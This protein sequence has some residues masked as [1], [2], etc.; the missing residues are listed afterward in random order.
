MD[1][2]EPIMEVK[3]DFMVSPAGDSDPSLR[4]A[5]FLKPIANGNGTVSESE[6]PFFSGHPIFEQWPLKVHFNGWRNLHPRW[7][8]WV[9]ALRLRYESVW[10]KAGMFDAIMSTTCYIMRNRD[11]AFGVA[12][13]WCSET[14]TFVFSWGEATITLE[15]VMVLGGYPVVGDPVFT[16]LESPE[17]REVEQKLVRAAQE[18]WR[19]KGLNPYTSKWID[20]FM[21]GGSEIEHEAF[22]AA[23][24][25]VFVFPRNNLVNKLLF[26]MA[27]LLARGNPIALAPAVLASIYKDLGVLKQTIADLTKELVVGY[28]LGFELEVNLWSPFNLVQ[29]WVW[30][31]F[32]NLQPE[33]NLTND[34]DPLLF[35]WSK[36]RALEIDNVRLALD[37]AIDDFV[38]RPYVRYG[39]KFRVFYPE[40]EI[41]QVPFEADLSKELA[42]FVTCMRVSQLVGFDST[43]MQYFP[44]RVAMQFGMDQDVPGRVPV[45]NGTRATA[46]ENY[47][48][49]ISDRNLYFP[50]RLFEADVTTRYARWWKQSVLHHQDFAKN[51]V[52]RKRSARASKRGPH[53]VKANINGNDA[54]ADAPPLS[55]PKLV[56]TVILRKSCDDGLKTVKVEND[57][58][59]PSRFLPKQL[60]IV[61]FGNSVQDGLIANEDTGVD[62][63]T[64][65][66]PKL[67]ALNPM[68]KS[69]AKDNT[70]P[71]LG[72]LKEDLEDANGIKG[73][74]LSSDKVRL[75]E[76]PVESCSCS[77]VKALDKRLSRLEREI[78]RLKKARL[79]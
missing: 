49:P 58:D 71:S 50:S 68:T 37:L 6:T 34:G 30:E 56:S 59:V 16:S 18:H 11:L 52:R 23:W 36:V 35:K 20:F 72:S 55:P 32:K 57:A 21:N 77:C 41:Q 42:S 70:E 33:P 61:P 24:L 13:K 17:M 66:P 3:E 76:I 28:E 48:R 38:W 19:S 26:P 78:S 1:E 47:C 27:V 63:P 74:R 67:D 31:R 8:R 60:H 9:N 7:V 51:I 46:W 43:I 53:V 64:N 75:F 73:S 29:V 39:G 5:H 45:F 15:D 62:V 4:T 65:F 54:I 40:N 44:H 79:H 12:E 25:S 69:N 22:L 10:K 14:N 2:P